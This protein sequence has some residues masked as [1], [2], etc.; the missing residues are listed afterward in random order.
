VETQTLVD[1]MNRKFL[2]RFQVLKEAS[3]SIAP[4]SLIEINRRFKGSYCLYHQCDTTLQYPRKQSS[5]GSLLIGWATI[6][7]YWINQLRGVAQKVIPYFWNLY[8]GGNSI[9]TLE[10][11]HYFTFTCR[12][13]T[14]GNADRSNR[15]TPHTRHLLSYLTSD[16]RDVKLL[17]L[18]INFGIAC[19]SSVHKYFSPGNKPTNTKIHTH[20]TII[21][22]FGL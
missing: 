18:G 11:G 4:Y 14:H 10:E 22:P 21:L 3:M 9:S 12:S 1:T 13:V 6:S 17:R 8:D 15:S 16:H 19:Y 7:F 2:M 20:K 5:L